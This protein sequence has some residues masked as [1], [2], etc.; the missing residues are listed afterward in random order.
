MTPKYL[1]TLLSMTLLSASY[2]IAQQPATDA[3]TAPNPPRQRAPQRPSAGRDVRGG[4][5]EGMGPGSH[6]APGGMWWKNPD[7][8]QKLTI[9]PDQQ[10]KMDDIFQKS[11]LQL[12]DLKATLE[13]EE[14]MLHPMLAANPLDTNKALAQIEHVAKSRADL[15]VANAKMLLGI[16]GVLTPDQWTKLQAERGSHHMGDRGP[17]GPG[18]K[19]GM[20]GGGPDG[21]GGRSFHF[22]TPDGPPEAPAV[23]GDNFQTR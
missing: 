3:P 7:I 23:S 20:M 22:T 18:G 19:G 2:A 16:R 21:P 17:G 1:S 14:V 10:A 6:F 11:R 5:P 4:R 13:K 8:I 15:E 9:T 12:I